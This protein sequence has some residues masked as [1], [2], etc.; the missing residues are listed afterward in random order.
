MIKSH[1]GR[2]CQ[3]AEE[4]QCGTDPDVGPK[5]R[6]DLVMGDFVSLN[7]RN[8]QAC[9]PKNSQKTQ[10]GGDHALEPKIFR[11]EQP[12]QDNHGAGPQDETQGLGDERDGPAT[13]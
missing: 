4:G 10:H 6:G 13:N 11:R 12:R 1:Q 8:A 5:K 9:V 7:S 2:S 3:H